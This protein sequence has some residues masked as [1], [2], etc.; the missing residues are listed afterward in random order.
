M[1]KFL[2]LY[3]TSIL[4]WNCSS[5]VDT[6]SLTA[7][8]HLEYAKKLML[9]DDYEEAIREFQ[10]ILLQYTGSSINDDAQYFLGFTYFKRE[11]YLL[12]AYEFSKVIRDTPASDFV[13]DSQFMLAES[14]FQ[15]SPSYQLE[16]SYSKKA[17]EEFQAFIEFFP[18]HPKVDEAEK[19]IAELYSKFAEKEYESALIYEKMEY[20]NAAIQYYE[21]VKNTYFDSKYAPL[22]HYRL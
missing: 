11:Q 16:Q 22:A 8:Q 3:L 12:S 2:V 7:E 1:K 17:I 20:F 19:K 6:T 15:L 10:S 4:I 9:D 13:Q 14:Y 18:T 21:N 5:S